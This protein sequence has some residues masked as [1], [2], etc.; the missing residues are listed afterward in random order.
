MPSSQR[1][2]GGWWW[3]VSQKTQRFCS[4]SGASP[5]LCV[6]ISVLLPACFLVCTWT[7]SLLKLKL[8]NNVFGWKVSDW[9]QL[10]VAAL[11]MARGVVSISWW[12]LFSRVLWWCF[13]RGSGSNVLT[14]ICLSTVGVSSFFHPQLDE[15]L[16]LSC[17]GAATSC[18]VVAI[19]RWHGNCSY[20]LGRF[21]L[22]VLVVKH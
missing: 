6:A 2:D 21:S 10:T 4:I 15:T 14:V 16:H 17:S 13:L 8:S 7:P 18:F 20:S 5:E 12:S 3:S 9:L 22:L 1:E 19:N 11:N